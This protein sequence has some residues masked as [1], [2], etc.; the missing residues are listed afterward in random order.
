MA[1]K[2][3]SF[4]SLLSGLSKGATYRFEPKTALE[5]EVY[6][7]IKKY[8]SKKKIVEDALDLFFKENKISPKL[9]EAAILILEEGV[10]S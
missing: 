8:G 5:L 7:V 9:R 6:G 1:T 4:E 10:G 3:R 2:K